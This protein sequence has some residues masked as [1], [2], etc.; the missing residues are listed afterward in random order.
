MQPVLLGGARGDLAVGVEHALAGARGDEER[1]RVL[2]PEDRRRQVHVRV[3]DAVHR[4]AQLDAL[5]DFTLRQ[6]ARRRRRS[7]CV[8][9][10]VRA[11]R[12]DAKVLDIPPAPRGAGA[13]RREWTRPASVRRMPARSS[14]M[15]PQNFCQFVFPPSIFSAASA[16]S[17]LRFRAWTAAD[18]VT[19]LRSLSSCGLAEGHLF[20]LIVVIV[21]ISAG[22]VENGRGRYDVADGVHG[23]AAVDGHVDDNATRRIECLDA[24]MCGDGLKC[25]RVGRR[26]A[27]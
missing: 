12:G 7:W 6:R 11:L 27:P 17:S 25:A 18:A 15:L 3:A 5:K 8:H 21:G 20:L 26:R 1:E 24:R 4:V 9:H 13:A 19:F 14:T 10:R 16:I 23:A 2:L 22:A